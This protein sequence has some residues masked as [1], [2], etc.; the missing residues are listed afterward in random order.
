MVEAVARGARVDGR[1]PG[2]EW[3]VPLLRD[4]D[5]RWDLDALMEV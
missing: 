5:S 3:S 1:G 4:D 2:L